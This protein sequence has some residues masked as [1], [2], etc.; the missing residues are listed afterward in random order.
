MEQ[1]EVTEPSNGAVPVL[2]KGYL[3]PSTRVRRDTVM[4]NHFP[5]GDLDNFSVSR[6]CLAR[7]QELLGKSHDYAWQR[8]APWEYAY[9]KALKEIEYKAQG[10][11]VSGQDGGFLAP[12]IWS[13]PYFGLLRA[14]SVLDQLPITKVQVPAR[15]RHLPKVMGDVTM[16]YPNENAAGT[17]TGFLIGQLT[18]TARK[19]EHLIPISNELIRDAAEMADQLLR[20]ESAMA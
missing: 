17:N 20:K 16:T 1:I 7:T 6:V 13:G 18:Y 2:E 14:F 19:A 5:L 4:V 9:Y 15:I 11:Y 3:P 10:E 12:E 8:D